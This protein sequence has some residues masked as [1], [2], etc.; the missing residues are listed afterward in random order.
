M[1]RNQHENYRTV[2]ISY[3]GKSYSLDGHAT[4]RNEPNFSEVVDLL[5]D[6]TIESMRPYEFILDEDSKMELD[7]TEAGVL[8]KIILI[9]D[10]MNQIKEQTLDRLSLSKVLKNKDA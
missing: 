7:Q 1:S 4:L 3:D 2:K 9:N 6:L 10:K 5:L 8:E